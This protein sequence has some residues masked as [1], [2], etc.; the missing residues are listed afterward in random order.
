MS[1]RTSMR[2]SGGKRRGL[3]TRQPRQVAPGSRGA[4][5]GSMFER[6]EN[7]WLMAAVISD[8]TFLAA[9]KSGI[10]V[11]A[12]DLINGLVPAPSETNYI[13]SFEGGPISNLTDGKTAATPGNTNE[14]SAQQNAVFSLDPGTGGPPHGPFWFAVYRL[15]L[16]GAPAGY[17]ITQID[18]I[19]GHQDNRTDQ[20]VDFEVQFIGDPNFYSLSN[21]N[22][23]SYRPGQGNGAARLRVTDDSGGP[24][25]RGVRAIRFEADQQAVY[26]EL[27][28]FGTV[29]PPPTSAPA[30][31]TNL[32]G[33][34]QGSNVRLT[35][36]DQA[37]N[38]AG[39][40]IERATVVGG[41]PGA[42]SLVGNLGANNIPPPAGVGGTVTFT[43]TTGE[44]GQTYQYRVGSFNAFN[45]GSTSAPITVNVTTPTSGQGAGARFFPVSRWKGNPIVTQIDP[46]LND[47]NFGAGSP[48][49]A[50]PPDQFSAIYSGK[51]TPTITGAYTFPLTVDD[52]GIFFIGGGDLGGQILASDNSGALG[53]ALTAGQ[54]YEFVYLASED[55]GD[56]TFNVQWTLPD[57]ID[58]TPIPASVLNSQMNPVTAAPTDV[59][60]SDV[61]ANAVTVTYTDNSVNEVKFQLERAPTTG[62]GAG[63]Y[64][65]V[66]EDVP[67][68]ASLTDATANPSTSYSYRVRAFNFEG[69][70]VST[71]I[72]VTTPARTPRNGAT[73]AWYNAGFWG[74][75]GRPPQNGQGVAIAPDYREE[76]DTVNFPNGT[77]DRDAAGTPEGAAPNR[78][79]FS[80][81]FTG[82]I[83]I[84][85][86]MGGEYK[87]ISRTDD[88]G[89]LFVN[90]QLVSYDP[91]GHGPRDA[92]TVAAPA[93]V[94]PITLQ[95]GSYNFVFLQAEQGGGS[96]AV[97]LWEG[98]ASAGGSGAR[99]VIPSE[100]LSNISD[101]PV[102]PGAG[103]PDSVTQTSAT[104]T[105]TDNSVSELRY[106]IEQSRDP[107]FVTID[108][109][110]SAPINANSFTVTGLT[111]NT[112]YYFR[113]RGT[114]LEGEGAPLVAQV[115][116]SPTP[117]P[118]AA[119]S[120]LLVRTTSDR[121]FRITFTD[122]SNNED[123]F[124][125]TRR[126][127]NTGDFTQVASLDPNVTV[128]QDL[129]F[130]APPRNTPVTYRVAS[131]NA[132][133]T[134]AP[135]E[136]TVLSGAPG[137]TG[138]S[139]TAYA[140]TD[141]TDNPDDPNDPK[142]Y[143][144][145][146]VGENWSLGPPI[147]GIPEDNFSV[148]WRG[149]VQAEKT[150]PYQ[151]Q[152][153]GDDAMSLI[154]TDSGGTEL[155]NLPLGGGVQTSDP[156]NLVAGQRYTIEMRHMEN[157]GG[158]SAF[159]RWS[160]TTTPLEVI[161]S[162]FLFPV[163][164]PTPLQVTQ[165]FVNGQ[166]MTNNAAFRTAGGIDQTFGYPIPDG[167]GQ[168]RPVPWLNGINA[169][170]IR[171]SADVA[172][173]LDQA[174]LSVRGTTA[175]P[176][177][178]T[179]FTYD[180]ATRT[181][182]WTLAAPVTL[183]KLRLV[184][185]A[186]GVNNLDGEWTNPATIGTAGDTYPSGNG[187][188]GGDFNFRLNVLRGD[189]TG[190]GQVNALDLADVK[191]R[192]NRRPNDGV[193]GA[194]AY[195]VFADITMDGQINALDLAAVKQRLNNRLPTPEPALFA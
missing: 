62:P 78:A 142:E 98:P 180:T 75:P 147:A 44:V 49:P 127:N 59:T 178:T 16:T 42:F 120:N 159:F 45:G 177:A 185:N 106:K 137:G 84:P 138:L 63:V 115:T 33:T 56:A 121:D 28:V 108:R 26:R 139:A 29:T 148:L 183:D 130:P 112:T 168:L 74:W 152:I 48:H 136:M 3:A 179:G 5:R 65:V 77:L 27:D 97:M 96:D 111:G 61:Q 151:F 140:T 50:V 187:T 20:T 158:A 125:I 21:N 105:F 155:V 35:F 51:I 25:A 176:I 190:D 43:D 40:R 79:N 134:S 87:F 165:V 144:D 19:T 14:F 17:D 41:N 66:A 94:T 23:F 72:N 53:V 70:A 89:A 181:G 54:S 128:F 103:T 64:S 116:T 58:P 157:S 194:G 171:F 88:D 57:A 82:K 13:R 118:P 76:V 175:G 162:V 4:A 100:N 169:V 135:V 153:Q 166:N 164:G 93:F 110:L 102:A 167:A 143:L 154:I 170:S 189:A 22:N 133:G 38:E 30:A 67:N 132:E 173:A 161:P 124:I 163:S 129:I 188:A 92:D 47:N 122:N 160:S 7:R 55:F 113:I 36:T 117:V 104:I 52:Q 31:P 6:L 123:H 131:Q 109:T 83:I 101:I 186:A 195:S 10:P 11:S 99:D 69:S 18:S 192:L 145:P 73:G 149:Q 95:P 119:P 107:N 24:L 86:G 80:T 172:G 191:R 182:T 46:N 1:Q 146:E 37:N 39:F 2:A 156:V 32:Q 193:T 15:N 85:A 91:G 71:A 150:E 81:A 9:Q 174:D 141:W 60:A 90:G 126:L 8:T 68:T 114:N 34:P 184:L 12:T